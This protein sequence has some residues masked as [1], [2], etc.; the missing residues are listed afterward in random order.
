M[1]RAV[2]SS[3][4]AAAAALSAA[5]PPASAA[6]P[7]AVVAAAGVQYHVVGTKPVEDGDAHVTVTQGTTILFVNADPIA[8]HT[9]SAVPDEFDH[10]AFD[11]NDGEPTA[12]GKYA[13]VDG[14]ESLAPGTYRF[15]CKVHTNLMNGEITVVPP[16]V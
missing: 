13:T 12:P 3:G 11:S 14:M 4:L 2:L 1:R 10:Y 6:V 5:P 8:P 9:L 16:A 7:S 15:Q